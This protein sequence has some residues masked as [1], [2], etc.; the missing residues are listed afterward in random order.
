MTE[1]G[2]SWVVNP[3]LCGD[4]EP[5]PTD[6]CEEGL[7]N[8]R[9][10][11]ADVCNYLLDLSGKYL[12]VFFLNSCIRI[13]RICKIHSALMQTAWDKS[14]IHI[15]NKISCTTYCRYM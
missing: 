6:P 10:E 15:A 8:T 12:S 11:A 13:I 9:E 2:N 3:E 1:F 4:V 5:G 7:E 14:D